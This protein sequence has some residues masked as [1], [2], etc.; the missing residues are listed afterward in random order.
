[1]NKFNFIIILTLLMQAC[2]SQH[3]EPLVGISLSESKPNFSDI[4]KSEDFN[5]YWLGE[6]HGTN[7]NYDI[8]FKYF[9]YLVDELGV[10]YFFLENT[11]I[12]EIL[13]NKYFK[14]GEEKFLNEAFEHYKNTFYYNKEHHTFY[15]NLYT[16][17]ESLPENKKFRFVSIDLE[18]N[19]HATHEYISDKIKQ[20]KKGN[21]LLKEFKDCQKQHGTEKGSLKRYYTK[22]LKYIQDDE[23]IFKELD[24]NV[25]ELK[26][27]VNNVLYIIYA[28]NARS[29]DGE[30]WN[31]IRDS[32][33]YENFKKR[34]E[35]FDFASNKSFAF[36]GLDHC[37]KSESKNGVKW[38]ASLIDANRPDIKQNS[39]A[40]L[41]SKCEFM[42]PQYFISAKFFRLFLKKI[43]DDFYVKKFSNTDNLFA[44]HKA[45]KNLKKNKMGDITMWSVDNLNP[46]WNLVI[47]KADDKITSEYIDNLILLTDSKYCTP[48]N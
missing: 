12:Y 4:F 15:K 5:I 25:E 43:N 22:L 39:T 8:A 32:L 47:E 2:V 14:T 28:R 17:Y 44:N 29:V 38:V 16:L 26:Y 11:R 42:I 19:V 20:T 27:L 18:H 21:T 35:E 48:Y 13:L 40:I 3:S 46:D 45:I 10:N 31:V 33:M 34:D 30:S 24:E 41:Y 1:M 7:A 36:F 9:Q 6:L 23:N 37:Y